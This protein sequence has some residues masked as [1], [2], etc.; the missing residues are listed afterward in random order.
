M[1]EEKGAKMKS[2]PRLVWHQGKDDWGC[3]Y[4]VY[5]Q[6]SL[7]TDIIRIDLFVMPSIVHARPIAAT[8]N[9]Y[10]S[11]QKVGVEEKT[12]LHD[13]LSEANNI[14]IIASA[15]EA[16]GLDAEL[17]A[18]VAGDVQT[19]LNAGAAD[20]AAALRQAGA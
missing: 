20:I 7:E 14:P 13:P 3:L 8:V 15:L 5:A 4:H 18:Y 17:S 16:K 9:R 2:I 1:A 11:G 10:R 6:F 19:K 12:A